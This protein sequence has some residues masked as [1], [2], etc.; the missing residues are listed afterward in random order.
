MDFFAE[1]DSQVLSNPGVTSVQLLSPDNAP[2]ARVTITRT[3]IEPGASQS[4]HA[5]ETS[6]QVWVAVSGSG[7]LL[8]AGGERKRIVAGGVVRFEAGDVHGF[9]NT[10]G[11][12]F[13]YMSVTSPPIDFGY[14]YGEEL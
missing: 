6:E 10:T 7:D 11:E 1:D 8:L 5:H 12:A 3:T 4:R 13:V 14:A 9:E 2:S